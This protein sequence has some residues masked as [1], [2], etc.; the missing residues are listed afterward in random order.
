MKPLV[1]IY[2]SIQIL[3]WVENSE[4][5]P[6]Y[7]KAFPRIVDVVKDT[8]DLV[9]SDTLSKNALLKILDNFSFLSDIVIAF[10]ERGVPEINVFDD[11]ETVEFIKPSTKIDLREKLSRF[12][13]DMMDEADLSC[14]YYIDIVFTEIYEDF[15]GILYTPI[16][17]SDQGIIN[18]FVFE[19]FLTLLYDSWETKMGLILEFFNEERR[20]TYLE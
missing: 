11:V 5:M 4:G 2:K 3:P 12:N 7:V 13:Q 8:E 18:N 16:D 6:S 9:S 19:V 1:N 20:K 17:E 15:Y 14:Y 10:A